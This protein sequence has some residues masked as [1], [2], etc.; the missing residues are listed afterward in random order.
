VVGV[1]HAAAADEW[2]QVVGLDT[3]QTRASRDGD[4]DCVAVDPR[5]IM[6]G[7]VALQLWAGTVGFPR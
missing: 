1:L 7:K 5:P 2:V 4:V 6:G 3:R